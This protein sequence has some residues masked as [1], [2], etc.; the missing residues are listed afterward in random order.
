MTF[1]P[2]CIVLAVLAASTAAR[3]QSLDLTQPPRAPSTPTPAQPLVAPGLPSRPE[4]PLTT[5]AP[6]PQAAPATSV[7]PSA[8]E[9]GRTVRLEQQ[10]AHPN[11]VA[12]TL[13][14]ITYRADS[15][16]V[17]A[18]I[19]NLSDRSMSLNRGGSLVLVDDRGRAHPFM[20]PADNPEVQIG[21]RSRVTASFVFAGPLAED[22][23][24]VQISTNGPSGSRSDR[25]TSAPAFL[26]RVP[27][28]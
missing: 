6:A 14:S 17:A 21:A 20:P 26:F 1:R 10:Q 7:A 18:S 16:I 12:M 13:T 19:D 22:A 11:G 8:Q 4:L 27:V 28:S 25:L 3:A 5:P 9:P 15:I 23:R 2:I 24:T